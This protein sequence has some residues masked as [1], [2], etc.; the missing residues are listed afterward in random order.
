[1]L[2]NH[3]DKTNP[4]VLNIAMGSC[5]DIDIKNKTAKRMNW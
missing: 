3:E 1:M 4:Q 5:D 2:T